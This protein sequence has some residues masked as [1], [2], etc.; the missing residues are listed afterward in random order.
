MKLSGYL[1][2]F[3]PV[4]NRKQNPPGL[5]DN[6]VPA[7]DRLEILPHRPSVPI[8][9][10]GLLDTKLQ[11]MSVQ[12]A[13]AN[14]FFYAGRN[15]IL[16]AEKAANRF[17]V[18]ELTGSSA[19]LYSLENRTRWGGG[20]KFSVLEVGSG[21]FL[22]HLPVYDYLRQLLAKNR[23][24]EDLQLQITLC[25]PSPAFLRILEI[26]LDPR[27][28][29][30]EITGLK[31]ERQYLLR[32]L[33]K[34]VL[35]TQNNVASKNHQAYE[36]D[37]F[38]SI[39][40]DK[41][42]KIVLRDNELENL[43]HQGLA[44]RDLVVS[45][46][47]LGSTTQNPVTAYRQLNQLR[48]VVG[49]YGGL[50]LLFSTGENNWPICRVLIRTLEDGMFEDQ[51]LPYVQGLIRKLKEDEKDHS[52][53]RNSKA[54]NLYKKNNTNAGPHKASLNLTDNFLSPENR[55]RNNDNTQPLSKGASD[56]AELVLDG[57][58]YFRVRPGYVYDYNPF[59]QRLD[60]NLREF[61]C[62]V[63]GRAAIPGSRDDQKA[64]MLVA[65]REPRGGF[66]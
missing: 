32:M 16:P 6:P 26:I 9:R 42:I 29:G 21:A 46:Y 3:Y 13:A 37:N 7:S 48:H 22:Y 47:A 19:F 52:N 49:Y 64:V 39:L 10:F 20:N 54:S 18:N 58:D 34:Y 66:L 60:S 41:N 31:G 17:M 1:P 25:E 50:V 8:M 61:G 56:D 33:D 27:Y 14:L 62:R 40:E 2:P 53:F 28:D 59:M 15:Y 57:Y 44:E 55:N 5:T 38:A 30:T 65:L 63:V 11:N 12:D 43:K 36:R 24:N 51:D 23:E 4:L 35:E 45:S